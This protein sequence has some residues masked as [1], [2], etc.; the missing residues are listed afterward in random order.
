[1]RP[2]VTV[3]YEDSKIGRE[4][5]LHRLLLRM[6]EDDINGRT[7]RLHKTVAGNP[8]NGIDK[9]LADVRVTSLIAGAGKLFLLVDRDRI[10][11]HVNRNAR[12]GEPRLAPGATDDEIVEAIRG[13]SDAPDRL[14]VFFLHRNMESLI[15]AIERCAP[16]N[17]TTEIAEAR[18]KNRLARDLVIR[19]TAKAA[20]TA[21]RTC[22]REAQ[23]GVDA[24]ARALAETLPAEAIA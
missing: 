13:T 21:V 4:Y 16:G 11:D 17:W 20:M 5:P 3:L 12:E 19:E 10:I 8:R 24:L 1:M 9:L 14:A 15:A 7:W 2:L 22:I 6:V 23:P 18:R